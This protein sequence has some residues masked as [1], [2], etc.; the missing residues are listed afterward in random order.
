M[1]YVPLLSIG[2]LCTL[3]S[4]AQAP[5]PEA[6]EPPDPVEV[7]STDT[8]AG[9]ASRLKRPIKRAGCRLPT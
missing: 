9:K 5:V 4:R 1:K 6:P 2:V 7:I 3:A 8:A